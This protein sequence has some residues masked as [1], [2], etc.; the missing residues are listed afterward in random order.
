MYVYIIYITRKIFRNEVTQGNEEISQFKVN[1]QWDPFQG[2]F[3][4]ESFLN[5]TENDIFSLIRIIPMSNQR[6]KMFF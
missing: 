3:A 4:L 2:Y 6:K 5:K 1:W